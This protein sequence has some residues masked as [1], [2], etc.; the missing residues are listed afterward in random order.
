MVLVSAFAQMVWKRLEEE[1]TL[2]MFEVLKDAGVVSF[3]DVAY[4]FSSGTELT[5]FLLG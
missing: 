1:F 3:I 4:G 2:H 5:D